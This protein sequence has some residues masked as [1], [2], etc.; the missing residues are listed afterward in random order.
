MEGFPRTFLTRDGRELKIDLVHSTALKEISEF[1]RHHFF[2]TSPNRYLVNHNPTNEIGLT[3]FIS[4]CLQS[5]VSLAVRD[6]NDRLVAVRLNSMEKFAEEHPSLSLPKNEL[7]TTLLTSLAKDIDLFT[8]YK[9]N[10]VFHLEMMAV[11]EQYSGLGLG[12]ML[13]KLSLELAEKHGA[14]AVGVCA[15]SEAA[16]KVA[17]RNGLE[18]LRTIDYST[19]ELNGEKPLANETQLLAEHRVA[20]FMARSLP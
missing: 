4:Q 13:V 9:T 16:A 6:S 3:T 17:A 11:D 10:K 19:F 14:G 7:T 18:T 2:E 20:K 12:S 8:I 5:S 1:L 15:V